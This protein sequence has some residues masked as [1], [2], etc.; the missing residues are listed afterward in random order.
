MWLMAPGLRTQPLRGRR[1]AQLSA[2]G[3]ASRGTVVSAGATPACPALVHPGAVALLTGSREIPA[4]RPTRTE[5]GQALRPLHAVN[6]YGLTVASITPWP[7]L[8][9]NV[10]AADVLAVFIN[11]SALARRMPSQCQLLPRAPSACAQPPAGHQLR[12]GGEMP[13]QSALGWR[14]CRPKCHR[15][16]PAHRCTHTSQATLAGPTVVGSG[17]AGENRAV[18]VSPGGGC[19]TRGVGVPGP[20]RGGAQT[21][22][23]FQSFVADSHRY[24]AGAGRA[25]SPQHA[26]SVSP[27]P[28]G[29]ANRLRRYRRY[30][31]ALA[32]WR[33]SLRFRCR[34]MRSTNT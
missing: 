33:R 6:A 27:Q 14:R 7:T 15:T 23:T 11:A 22:S 19:W 25:G 30:V 1:L 24:R 12:R 17:V 9:M 10:A 2:C 16:A 32:V 18:G 29:Y 28:R 31:L 13:G 4:V 21:G 5:V 34:R 3:W 8:T 26:T 20:A